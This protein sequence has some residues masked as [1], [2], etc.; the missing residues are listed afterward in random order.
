MCTQLK[1]VGIVCYIIIVCPFLLQ[2]A[3]DVITKNGPNTTI[4]TH[5]TAPFQNLLAIGMT[6]DLEYDDLQSSAPHPVKRRQ[7]L[8]PLGYTRSRTTSKLEPDIVFIEYAS[9]ILAEAE[10]VRSYRHRADHVSELSANTV[11]Y[12][13]VTGDRGG[14]Q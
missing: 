13:R 11:P 10:E 5:H 12:L 4:R 14:G 7:P 1:L 8:L 3:H 2:S 6:A 9:D